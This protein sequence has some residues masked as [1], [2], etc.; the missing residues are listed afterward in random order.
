VVE[1]AR[2]VQRR[3]PSERRHTGELH[4]RR[5]HG[6]LDAVLDHHH[7]GAGPRRVSNAPAT[8]SLISA[9]ATSIALTLAQDPTSTSDATVE[10]TFDLLAGAASDP[11]LDGKPT[12]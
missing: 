6:L 10:H 11:R 2:R 8:A 1:P 7:D 5:E 12:D 4:D 9:L 3:Q